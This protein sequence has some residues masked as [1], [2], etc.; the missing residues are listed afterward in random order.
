MEK[1]EKVKSNTISII[2]LHDHVISH[3]EFYYELK[4]DEMIEIDKRFLPTLIAEKL[5]TNKG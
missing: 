3:N 4:K 2:P 1:E 5:I